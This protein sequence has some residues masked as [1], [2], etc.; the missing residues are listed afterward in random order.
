MHSEGLGCGSTFYMKLPVYSINQ[1]FH[2]N[3]ESLPS[4]LTS[5]NNSPSIFGIKNLSIEINN[6][7]ENSS[8]EDEK[9]HTPEE[10]SEEIKRKKLFLGLKVLIV[11]DAAM[12]RK[13]MTKL[14]SSKGSICDTAED[15]L[16]AVDIMKKY[17]NETSLLN[18][19]DKNYDIIFMDFMMPNMDGPQATREIRALGYKGLIIGVTGNMMP[20][21]V[22]YF[23][24]SGA[25]TILPKPLSIQ[26]LQDYLMTK[27]H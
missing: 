12:I 7:N 4:P 17:Y 22:D 25:D 11:D 8:I 18:C 5:N 9:I 24:N 16:F 19:N 3:L 2:N 15:G 23:M 13:L 14:L 21:D 26:M 6:S 1:L 10:L 27:L 20:T